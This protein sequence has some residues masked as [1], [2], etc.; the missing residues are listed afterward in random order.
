MSKNNALSELLFADSD[1]NDSRSEIDDRILDAGKAVLRREAEALTAFAEMPDQNFVKAVRLLLSIKGRVIIT[2]MGKSG[3]IGAKISSTFA[4]T[5]TASFFVHPGEASHGDLGMI[6]KEDAVI[7]LSNSG[8]TSELFDVISYVKRFSI[9]LIGFVSAPES[10]L[11]KAAEVALILPKFPEA[12]ING[13]APTVSTT[14]MLALG[15][16]L[17]IALMERKGFTADCFRVF[18]PGGKLGARLLKVSDLMHYGDTMPIVQ[19]DHTVAETVLMMTSKSFGCAGVL[20]PNG[21]LIGIVTDGDLRRHISDNFILKKSADIMTINPITVLPGSPASEAVA[22][23]EKHKVTGLFVRDLN[24]QKPVGFIH[25]HD[26][27]RAGV[28]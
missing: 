12:C 10:S 6:T 8:E 20:N 13:L 7:C 2:G 25:I 9:P 23:M 16:A 19:E 22:I 17:A 27:L 3:H 21:D 24:E 4:S 15:D 26:C 1:R 28:V 11:A 18:H 5:G 14:L